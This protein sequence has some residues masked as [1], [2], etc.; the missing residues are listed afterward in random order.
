MRVRWSLL[1]LLN[2]LKRFGIYFDYTGLGINY[3]QFNTSY[4]EGVDQEGK[5]QWNGNDGTL[6]FGM[7]GSEVVLQ[8]GQEH[9]IRVYNNSGADIANGS[10]CYVESAGDRKPRIALADADNTNSIPEAVVVGMAT[11]LIEYET[12]GYITSSGVVRSLDT[13]HL[14]E[15][16]PV[17]LSTTPG[18]FTETKPTSPNRGIFI[19]HCLY[20]HN[21]QGVILIDIN[22]IPPIIGLSDVLSA[23]P[24]DGDILVWVAANSRFELQQPT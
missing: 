9:L 13:D 15:G 14:T 16:E 2:M 23:A 11:E 24:N 10:V 6:E 8:V 19:G 5:V 1:P 12:Q 7:I 18:E 3:A 21:S 20:K 4:D 17:W 22:P